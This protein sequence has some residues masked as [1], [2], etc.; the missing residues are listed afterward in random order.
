MRN[1][2]DTVINLGMLGVLCRLMA[3]LLMDPDLSGPRREAAKK[4]VPAGCLA[5][6]IQRMLHLGSDGA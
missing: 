5:T 6:L 2:R 4:N 3:A 1:E